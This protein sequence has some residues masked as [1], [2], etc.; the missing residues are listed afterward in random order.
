MLVNIINSVIVLSAN[1]NVLVRYIEC[2]QS[3][4]GCNQ[5]FTGYNKFKIEKISREKLNFVWE[6]SKQQFMKIST[7]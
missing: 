2:G 6:C 5:F 3:Y 7:F 4:P 1:Y